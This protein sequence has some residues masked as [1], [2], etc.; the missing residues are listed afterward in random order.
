MADEYGFFLDLENSISEYET[1]EYYVV[2]KKTHY[3]VRRKS[4]N[5]PIQPRMHASSIADCHKDSLENVA[6]FNMP[7]NDTTSNRCIVSKLLKIPRDIYYSCIICGTSM[8]CIY[9]VGVL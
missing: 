6:C 4:A 7:E 2:R 5:S 9:L 1:V 3:E 8:S